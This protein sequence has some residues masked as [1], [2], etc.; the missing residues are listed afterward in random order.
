M[1]LTQP[2]NSNHEHSIRQASRECGCQRSGGDDL[3]ST[4]HPSALPEV[5]GL[6]RLS[7]SLAMLDAIL[8]P[9]WQYRYHSFNANWAAGE[10]MASMRNGCGDDYFIVFSGADAIIKG[11]AHES[12]AWRKTLELGHPLS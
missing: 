9:E 4:R 7:Q 6:R 12:E 11:F 2:V 1:A 10:E 8:C 3:P 5:G